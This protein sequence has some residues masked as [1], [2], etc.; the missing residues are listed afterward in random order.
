[1]KEKRIYKKRKKR[2]NIYFLEELM[3]IFFGK[4]CFNL[5]LCKCNVVMDLGE[6]IER[7]LSIKI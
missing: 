4:E 2:R 3:E 5:K 7:R 1:M 6:R